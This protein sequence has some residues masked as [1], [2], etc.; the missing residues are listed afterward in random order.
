MRRT[1]TLVAALV[2]LLTAASSTAAPLRDRETAA[3]DVPS[4]RDDAT[5]ARRL[6]R[7]LRV[8]HVA[9]SESAAVAVDLGTGEELFALNASRPLAP[10]SNEKL[11]LTFALL[12]TL[13]PALRIETTAK[14]IGTR[15]GATLRGGIAL[16]GGGDPTLTS[17]DL[18]RLARG[19]RAAG[20]RRIT[21]GVL[22][23]ESLFDA[24]RT[25]LGWKPYFYINE[26]P[27]LS[28]LVVDRA[29]YHSYT[30]RRPAKA[31]ALLFRDA[32]RTAGV[33]VE[34]NVAVRVTPPEAP[35][36]AKTRSARL[37]SIIAFM[38]LHSDNF[39]AEQLLKLLS[40]TRAERGSS[41]A[42]AQVV[43][44]ALADAGIPTQGVRIVDGSGLS[45]KDRLTTAAL[46]G[47]LQAIADDPAREGL[48]MRALPVAGTSGTLKYRM[49]KPPL[50]GRV[51]AKT[52]TTSIASSLS[53]YVDSHI[54]FAII[55]NGHP[56]AS[57]W[58][59]E[60][61][62]RFAKVLASQG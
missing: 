42:G 47:I 3:R 52:G 57:W 21:G 40:L 27:P 49:Q 19:V 26:S 36:L 59:R 51:V 29:W 37:A 7:A 62:D 1:G 38:D 39:T 34:G 55:Q 41:A 24:K 23:D 30:A 53:G 12:A 60:A 5:L 16:V 13:S 18:L 43:M 2:V 56:I 33:A 14:A 8:P 6:A 11:A 25:C 50:H 45:A 17:S 31:A 22:G 54:A 58:A 44:T 46:V 10:A 4:A 35:I 15:E 20:I 61:Q 48:L 32:L 9:R 28:A